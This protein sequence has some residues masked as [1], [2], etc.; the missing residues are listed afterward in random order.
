MMVDHDNYIHT[1]PTRYSNSIIH[2]FINFYHLAQYACLIEITNQLADS[3]LRKNAELNCFLSSVPYIRK[4]KMTK[5]CFILFTK[6][7]EHEFIAASKPSIKRTKIDFE[8]FVP[9]S[10]RSAVRLD[11]T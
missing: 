9:Q 7:Q 4:I 8:V 3:E 11:K 6:K 2:L 10:S 1:F 5:I